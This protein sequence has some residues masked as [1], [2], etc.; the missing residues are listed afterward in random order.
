MQEKKPGGGIPVCFSS[1][2]FQSTS[3]PRST[4]YTRA[5]YEHSLSVTSDSSQITAQLTARLKRLRCFLY[6]VK[7]GPGIRDRSYRSY[8]YPSGHGVICRIGVA[9]IH[10]RQH[11][12][13]HADRSDDP[14]PT[15][16]PD[17]C[18]GNTDHTDQG[19]AFSER[20]KSS[21]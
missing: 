2:S 5:P 16:Q 10:T 7:F 13:D 6:C 20:H 4:R 15:R 17:L 21:I 18:I 11:M 14:D 9:Q 8:I 19:S 1:F 12:P 3:P